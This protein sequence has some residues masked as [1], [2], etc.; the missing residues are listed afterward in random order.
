MKEQQ[1]YELTDTENVIS[2]SLLVYPERI[3]H[4]IRMM[5][6]M[7]GGTSNL[8]PHIKTHK[9]AEI[10]KMQL[11]AGIEKF[12]CATIAE[13]ELLAM[14]DA[15]DVLLAMQPVGA[16]ISRFLS[17]MQTY[18]ES[19]FSALVDNDAT[20]QAFTKKAKTHDIK[21]SLW[22]DIN[23]GMNRT[24]ILPDEKAV[25]LYR[26]MESESNITA[27][28]LHVYDGHLRNPNPEE[29]KKD[30]DTAFQK[31]LELKDKLGEIGIKVKS[32]VAGGS[33]SFP[34]HAERKNVEASPGTTLLWDAGYGNLFPKMDFLP[35]AV[36]MTRII[37]K[38][39]KN[40]LCLD[41]GHKSLAPEMPFPRV[42]FF[43]IEG[44][45][46]I[47]QSEEHFVV[48]CENNQEYKVGDV[49]YALPVHICPTVAKYE[50]LQV[51]RHGK[52]IGTWKVAARNQ[53]ITI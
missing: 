45:K 19:K 48:E 4:N 34:F 23:N 10:I 6:R 9:T 36:L 5:I 30:C 18:P 21:I 38:P 41:L 28:G 35:A 31:V 52:I 7:T 14:C 44:I 15:P 53:K 2:P 24:G 29:R 40:I 39:A 47:G 22:M 27:M 13:A 46:Q 50:Y 51:V 16:N 32:I 25:N 42:Q 17:L 33:P 3:E 8:R 37:S 11:D 43:G 20:L 49:C 1:W 12:K 26:S